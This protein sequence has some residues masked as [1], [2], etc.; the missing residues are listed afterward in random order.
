MLDIPS[1]FNFLLGRPWIHTAGVV[2]SSLHQKVRFV[3]DNRL[4]TVHGESDFKIYHETTIPYVEP[5]C[6][7]E[8]SFQTFELVSMVHVPAGSFT[9]VPELSKPAIAAGKIMLVSGYNPGEG[10]GSHGQGVRKPIEA[11]KNFKR[12]GL[13]YFEKWGG[14]NNQGGR[15]RN[16]GRGARGGRDGYRDQSERVAHTEEYERYQSSFSPL[17]EETFPGPPRML[18]EEEE[19]IY[20]VTELFKEDVICT[21]LACEEA[22]SS[23]V[24]VV[25]PK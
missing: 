17:L 16:G 19:D 25:P 21:I 20:G 9:K 13:G 11:R 4:I 12:R 14:H 24:M 15:G 8:S 2:A 7:E 22:E 6:T 5:E 3:V 23:E 10:L 18:F 1:A